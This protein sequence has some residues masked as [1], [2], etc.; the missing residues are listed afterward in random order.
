MRIYLIRDN[1]F[2]NFLCNRQ[3]RSHK[4][5]NVFGNIILKDDKTLLFAFSADV[6]NNPDFL[7]KLRKLYIYVE[8]IMK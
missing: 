7:H 5:Y 2:H 4:N 3:N 8:I 1:V 6:R